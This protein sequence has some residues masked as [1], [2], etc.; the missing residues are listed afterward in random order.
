MS[1]VLLYLL[2]R[3]GLLALVLLGVMTITFFIGRVLPSSPVE[4][5]LGAKPTA[6]QVERMTREL[7]LDRPLPQQYARFI[8]ELL[9]GELGRSFRTNRP[10][11][12]EVTERAGASIE[13]VTIALLVAVAIGVPL[14]VLL[15]VSSGRRLEA[16]LRVFAIAGG[17]IPTF[18]I[19]LFL[20][21]V[22]FGWLGWLP[23]NGRLGAEIPIDH[24]FARAT[25]IHLLDALIGGDLAA[26]RSVLIHLVLPVS[27]LAL[28]SVAV[29]ARVTGNLMIE[30]LGADYIRTARACGLRERLIHFKLALRPALA[31]LLT[32]VGLTYGFLLGNSVFV[33]F[34]FD[35]PGLGEYALRAVLENDYPAVMGVTLVLAAAYLLVNLVV[36]LVNLVVD[37]R[38]R[39]T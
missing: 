27:A 28:S 36:D 20:Q 24:P 10:V 21:L 7:G 32:I 4:L 25:G 16:A 38:L 30:V 8:R 12:V 35:W 2:R 39:A 17:A 26:V 5:L 11:L 23:L 3:L 19:G 13:L 29:L 18:F 34:I 1:G 37:P 15:A 22:F 33:E 9:S 31:S 6:E 14:G